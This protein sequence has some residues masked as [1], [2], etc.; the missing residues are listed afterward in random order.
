MLNNQDIL[1]NVLWGDV[2][3]P[4]SVFAIDL[5]SPIIG[6]GGLEHD[7]IVVWKPRRDARKLIDGS[8]LVFYLYRKEFRN[9]SGLSSDWKTTVTRLLEAG[10]YD[11]AFGLLNYAMRDF[12]GVEQGYTCPQDLWASDNILSRLDEFMGALD[13]GGFDP[14]ELMAMRKAIRLAVS[15][16]RHLELNPDNPHATK[17]L[18]GDVTLITV[19]G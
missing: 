9:Y 14:D 13:F 8:P 11:Q 4:S 19:G 18:E 12:G 5:P 16:A 2:V 7:F 10:D 1:A 15:F 17:T 3:L 6:A